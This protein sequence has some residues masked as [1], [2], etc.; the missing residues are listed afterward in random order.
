MSL[1]RLCKPLFANSM[2]IN[3]VLHQLTQVLIKLVFI[4]NHGSMYN[5]YRIDSLTT[6]RV[7]R[8]SIPSRYISIELS[9]GCYQVFLAVTL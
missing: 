7:L 9:C 1:F 6:L 8:V 3:F 5:L 4:G 2:I